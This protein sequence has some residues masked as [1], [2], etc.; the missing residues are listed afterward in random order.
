MTLLP[1]VFPTVQRRFDELRAW[2]D[3]PPGSKRVRN[4]SG[5]AS[6][7]RGMQAGV[8]HGRLL[9]VAAVLANVL[10]PDRGLLRGGMPGREG[11]PE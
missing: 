3:G 8:V 10:K 1:R 6:S 2:R 4:A 11:V 7:I 5:R 9:D